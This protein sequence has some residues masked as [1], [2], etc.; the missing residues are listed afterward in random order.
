LS[1]GPT[2][3][4]RSRESA[5]SLGLVNDLEG[6]I[7]GNDDDPRQAAGDELVSSSSKWHKHTIKVFSLLKQNIAGTN[8]KDGSK[9]DQ[10]SFDHLSSGGSR[11]T[12]AGVF[13]ELLQLKTWDFIEL[14]QGESYGDI[15]VRIQT[16]GW[17]SQTRLCAQLTH[18]FL[19]FYRSLRV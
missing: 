3:S 1:L 19:F 6:D 4:Q 8:D 17:C 15:K 12:A 10:L 13:F 16:V 2:G 7:I 14:D 18:I 9:P 11:R 5:L